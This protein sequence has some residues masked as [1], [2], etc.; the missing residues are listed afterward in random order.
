MRLKTQALAFAVGR[1]DIINDDAGAL[2]DMPMIIGRGAAGEKR[3][4]EDRDGDKS[5][6]VGRIRRKVLTR[7]LAEMIPRVG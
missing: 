1:Q 6:H 7:G 5:V 2:V 3:A 4:G